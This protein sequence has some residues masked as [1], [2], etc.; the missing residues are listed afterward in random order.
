MN[1][2][3]I[4]DQL[5]TLINRSDYTRE[6]GLAVLNQCQLWIQNEG[7]WSFMETLDE[8]ELTVDG[9]AEYD[10]PTR[11]KRELDV[12]LKDTVTKQI[13]PLTQWRSTVPDRSR[14]NY[15]TEQRPTSY[16]YFAE[17]LYLHPIPEGVY[18]IGQRCFCYLADLTDSTGSTNKLTELHSRLLICQ[19]ARDIFNMFEDYDSAKVWHA[20]TGDGKGSNFML[21]WDA[22]QKKE[23]K[24]LGPVAGTRMT[25][26]MK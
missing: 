15:E 7:D 14:G 12:Y 17:K 21:E 2:S 1:T 4:L 19:A 20:G 10:P 5:T 24:K 11:F 26:R 25:V 18:T 13:Y 8:N 9:T 6:I 16:Y 23:A 22:F 3:T